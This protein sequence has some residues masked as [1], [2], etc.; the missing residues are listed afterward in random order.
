[1]QEVLKKISELHSLLEDKLEA[2]EVLNRQLS[3]QKLEQEELNKILIAK[4]NHLKAK[5]RIYS[6]YDS[7]E[8]E[9]DS[10]NKQ[11]KSYE[12]RMRLIEKKEVE[13][14]KKLKEVERETIELDKKKKIINEQVIALK[15]REVEFDNKKKELK[16]ILTGEA[17]KGIIK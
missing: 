8:N 10:F 4:D 9:V 13:I 11:R 14:N 12:D 6:K 7:F 1:M 17:I 5:E 3:K 16:G 15:E 2:T